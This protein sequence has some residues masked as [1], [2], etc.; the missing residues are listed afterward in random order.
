L[1]VV[2]AN[3]EGKGSTAILGVQNPNILRQ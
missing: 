1:A 2:V 3:S